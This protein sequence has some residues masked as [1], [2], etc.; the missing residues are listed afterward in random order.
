[1][2]TFPKIA[3]APAVIVCFITP[4]FITTEFVALFF[5]T[6]IDRFIVFEAVLIIAFSYFIT[7]VKIH[8]GILQAPVIVHGRNLLALPV[9]S[10][11]INLLIIHTDV[12][13]L[14]ALGHAV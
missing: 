12:L 8:A 13:M 3:F 4:V 1:M 14:L 5:A 6:L 10:G 9:C 7:S 11:C 2:I